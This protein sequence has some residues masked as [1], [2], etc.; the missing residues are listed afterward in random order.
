MQAERTH[1]FGG[2]L[3][4]AIGDGRR[5]HVLYGQKELD[6]KR[7]LIYLPPLQNSNFSK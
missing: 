2:V 7:A 4:Q 1:I 3:S 6:E 5:P